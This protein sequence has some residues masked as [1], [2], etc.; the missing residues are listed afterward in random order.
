MIHELKN[1]LSYD[2]C[3]LLIRYHIDNDH[4]DIYDGNEDFHDRIINPSLIRNEFL[5]SQIEILRWKIVQ[6]AARLFD[7]EY[8]FLEWWSLVY[9]GVGM[10]MGPH[11]DCEYENGDPHPS[12]HKHYSCIC[13]L[14]ENYSGGETYFPK[15]N[16]SIVPEKAKCV[17]FP[18]NLEY[19][20][21]VKEITKGERYTLA[22]WFTKSPEH[23]LTY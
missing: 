17:F 13:Y 21:G 22:F 8:L 18:G 2:F 12:P 15:K 11:S 9:W 16:I 20:H 6:K 10:N 3:N 14:N 1:Y 23:M 19:T 7:E 5:K 4:Y